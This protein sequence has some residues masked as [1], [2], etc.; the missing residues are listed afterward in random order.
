[1]QAAL[2][3]IVATPSPFPEGVIVLNI[4]ITDSEGPFTLTVTVDNVS[5]QL[6]LTNISVST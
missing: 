1:M 2:T 5:V 4:Q 6:I 3:A